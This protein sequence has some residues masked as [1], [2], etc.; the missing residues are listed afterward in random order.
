MERKY[1]VGKQTCLVK[2]LREVERCSEGKYGQSTLYTCV[3]F[4][5]E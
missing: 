1:E 5:K 2:V 3:K 4:F